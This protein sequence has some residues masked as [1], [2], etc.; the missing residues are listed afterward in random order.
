MAGK[1]GLW[2]EEEDEYLMQ[3][4]GIGAEF[5]ASH[6]LGRPKKSGPARMA[7]LVETGA[8]ENFAL[9]MMHLNL[10]RV[11]VGR[12]RSKFGSALLEGEVANWEAKA[13]AWAQ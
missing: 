1:K 12:D 8:A 10:Y 2:S 9:A 5:I 7:K 13:L 4:I 6:D 11:Q 3:Y